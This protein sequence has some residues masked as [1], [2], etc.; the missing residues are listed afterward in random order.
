[1]NIEFIKFKGELGKF[2]DQDYCAKILDV[3]S[4]YEERIL[5]FYEKVRID[6]LNEVRLGFVDMTGIVNNASLKRN[7][8]DHG[9]FLIRLTF[10]CN[11]DISLIIA[12]EL[13]HMMQFLS[14][15]MDS[16]SDDPD[17]VIWKGEIFRK[18][19]LG[20][21]NMPWEKDAK[22]NSFSLWREYDGW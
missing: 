20:P 22:K 14:G 15:W 16:A 17:V 6:E 21:L 3:V 12:H 1:M 13:C 8:E 9:M 5:R 18:S 10:D 7:N 4:F 19:N 2:C 11:D